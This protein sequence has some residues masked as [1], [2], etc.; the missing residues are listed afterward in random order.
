[1]PPVLSTPPD[2]LIDPVTEV[3]HGVSVTD[4]YRWL[5]DQH[6]PRTRQWITEQ[7]RFG[8]S[9]L[10][11][12]P[13]R[14]AI[15]CRVRELLTVETYDSL[16]KVKG[17]Y[18]FRKRLANQEQ[19]GIWM[20]DGAYGEDQ[21]LIDPAK[22]R[23]GPFTA[24]RPLR[25][26]RDGVLLLY[27]VKEGG[28]RAA[29]FEILE[30]NRRKALPD[31]LP[32]G[33]LRGFAFARDA[34][35]FYYVHEPREQREP[36][37][38]AAYQHVLGTD[39][40]QDREVFRAGEDENLRLAM[41]SDGDRVGF[42]VH[43]FGEESYT[44]F[45]L[46]PLP[47][48]NGRAST[49][50]LHNLEYEFAPCFLRGRLL[51]LTDYQA[52]NRRIVE[53]PIGGGDESSF[54]DVVPESED[55]ITS[56]FASRERLYI[57]YS[58]E[59][60]TRIEIFDLKREPVEK[61]GE[62]RSGPYKTIR[63]LG[64]AVDD[65]EFFFEAQS[66]T[67]P[68]GIYRQSARETP[69]QLWARNGKS[70]EALSFGQTQVWYTSKDG[71]SVPMFLFGRK[72]VLH[73][74]PQPTVMTSYGGHGAS[75]T[76]Q[77]SVLVAF[78][79]ERGCLFALPNIRGGS[80]LG[81]AW[82]LGAKRQSRQAAFDDFISAAEWLIATGRT[83]PAQLGIFGGSNSGLLVGAA[84]TQRPEL[85]RAVLCMVPMLDMLRYHLFDNAYVWKD[86][87]GTS[88]DPSDFPTLLG[89]SPYHN[90][91]DDTAYPATMIVSGD[92]DQNCNPSHARKMTARLQAANASERPIF[93]DYSPHRG[94]SPV[95][96]LSTRIDALADRLAFL[97]HELNVTV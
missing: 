91:H 63:L 94:H 50:I 52:S 84:F 69:A 29:K 58:H 78:L 80:E 79:V 19:P 70:L 83:T 20:R 31:S 11:S 9:Y 87:F 97:C 34:K 36:F 75:M 95:L 7:I 67:E 32:H 54:R 60:D 53:L 43:R 15:C 88:D 38:R 33:Y 35:S 4:P 86:E 81:V 51:A 5:E 25:V 27:E 40:S 8:R 47:L 45:Y 41:I 39:R 10:D 30:V 48:E 72:D 57:D 3:L 42:V 76:P 74:G 71:T 37:R 44:D 77:F 85:F 22:R 96:P 12:L 14:E 55:R 26:S 16:Q 89:Y 73:R 1:M 2:S 90:V 64:A 21:V 92:A 68:I 59:T 18:F 65:D 23:T 28:E 56:W 24:V 17:R 66:F 6:S 93:L 49:C 13:D 62:V 82:H 46:Q 61:I